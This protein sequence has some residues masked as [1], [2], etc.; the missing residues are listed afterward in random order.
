[1][2]SRL[3]TESVS[4][5]LKP[6]A[7]GLSFIGPEVV[8]SG[9]VET[10]AQLHVD[11]RI[12][13]HV[14]CAVLCQGK[15]GTVSGNINADD[16]RIAGLVEGAVF[17]INLTLE[18]T[19]RIKGDITY[20]TISIAAGAQVDGRLARRESLSSAVGALDGEPPMLT[21]TPIGVPVIE[22]LVPT[23][24]PPKP[25]RKSERDEKA[26]PPLAEDIFTLTPPSQAGAH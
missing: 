25:A 21:A 3:R 6:G 13:G 1:M 8:V 15:S 23:A 18:P 10:A 7:P 4:K 17:A 22:P 16:A 14:R 9:D 24:S 2:F 12:D 5:P 11:G 26:E 20:Q 19:A